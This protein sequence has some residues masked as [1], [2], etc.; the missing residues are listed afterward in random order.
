MTPETQ[1]Y[2]HNVDLPVKVDDF[3]T[4]TMPVVQSGQ[5]DKEKQR[6]NK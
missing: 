4:L 6:C 5:L 1:D 3:V 2:P